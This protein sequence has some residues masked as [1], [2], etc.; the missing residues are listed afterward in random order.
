M[1]KTL[2]ATTPLMTRLNV[3][4]IIDVALVLVIILLITAPMLDIADV[5]VTLPKA[6]TRGIED[7]RRIS[8]TMGSS[9]R[10]AIDDRALEPEMLVHDLSRRI[11]ERGAKT[12]VVVRADSGATHGEVRALIDRVRL[13]GAERIAVG[14]RQRTRGG[15]Q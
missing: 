5:G 2:I 11:A 6:E 13:A 12:L 3:T 7:E 14:T 15:K 10:L 9:G 4:P 1:R 8:V